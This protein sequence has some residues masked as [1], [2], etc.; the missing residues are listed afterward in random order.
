MQELLASFINHIELAKSGSQ[1]TNEAYQRDISRFLTFLEANDIHD[2]DKVDKQLIF[3]YI[4]LLRSGK[5]TNG[6]ITN[7][8]YSRNLSALRSFFKYLQKIQAVQDNPFKQFKNPKSDK[9][10][11]DFLTYDEI[12]RLLSALDEDKE[13]ELRDK[14]IISLFYACG[15]RLNELASLKLEDIDFEQA[16][17]LVNGKGNKERIVPFY[18]ECGL[19]MKKY[20]TN[21]RV[22]WLKDEHHYVFIN[23]QGKPLSNRYIQIIC[24]KAG[25]KAGIN[26]RIHPHM[27]RHSFA[28]HLLDNGADLR[29][30][31]ELLGH[32]NLST[33]QIYT[34]ISVDKLKNVIQN[35]HPRAKTSLF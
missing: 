2:L 28:T 4:T 14:A 13:D 35:A 10:L 21:T 11:P 27:I 17:V 31:Q 33:T 9:K 12:E 7:T 6:K 25:M 32:E 15:L 3:R 34:H 5:I 29:I 20:L 19:I 18:Q 24:E 30:V 22:K 23:R 26:K 16:F 8:T 1:A